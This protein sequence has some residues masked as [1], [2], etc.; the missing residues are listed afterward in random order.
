MSLHLLLLF[1]LSFPNGNLLFPSQFHVF[2]EG[3]GALMPL[4]QPHPRERL[5]ARAVPGQAS[6]RLRNLTLPCKP[7]IL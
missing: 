7:C 1:C 6:K 2:P 4:K 3:A 5:Q